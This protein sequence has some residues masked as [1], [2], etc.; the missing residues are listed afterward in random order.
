MTFP[1]P[2]TA[3]PGGTYTPAPNNMYYE[4]H[5]PLGVYNAIRKLLAQ[6]QDSPNS[7]N[8][9]VDASK[10]REWF[11][12]PRP[13]TQ[14]AIPKPTFFYASTT[15]FMLDIFGIGIAPL[16]ASSPAPI[17]GLDG[18]VFY[19]DRRAINDPFPAMI[20]P[21]LW[22][23]KKVTYSSAA[24]PMGLSIAEGAQRI[25][26]AIKD[27]PG[28][29][30]LG[31]HGQG[32]AVMSRVLKD[33][34]SGS[35][36]NR[37]GDLIAAT[38]FGNPSR[39]T[40]KLW[41][42]SPPITSWDDPNSTN[43]HGS[44]P[45]D[46]RLTNTPSLWWEFANADDP[47]ASTGDTT[48]GINWMV[49]IG[50]LTLQF[51]GG[52][53]LV[54]FLVANL[55]ALPWDTIGETLEALG[56]GLDFI[57]NGG[58]SHITYSTAPPTG[59]P[60]NGKTSYQIA[61]EYL[62]ETG[63]QYKASRTLS[64]KTEVLQI[65]FKLPMP[66]NDVAFQAIK[67]PV[68]IDMWYRDRQ[69]NWRA[70]LDENRNPVTLILGS[71]SEESWHSYNAYTS[72]T[73]AKSVQFRMTRLPEAA[74][75]TRPYCVGL[76]N[77]LIRRNIYDRPSGV[78]AT[79]ITEDALGNV[80][81]TYIKD[82]DAPKAID[83]N[84]DTFWRSS[85]QPSPDAVVALYLDMRTED[86]SP[87]LVD[88]LYI[89]PVY[90]GNALNIYYTNDEPEG[91]TLEPSPISV[92][93]TAESH[94]R[95]QAGRGLWDVATGAEVSEF[96]APLKVGPLVKK[97]CWIGVEW[98]PDFVATSPPGTNPV[99]LE[100]IPDNPEPGQFWPR[101]YYDVG[102]LGYGKI[103]LEFTNGTTS[104]LF[105][106]PL[107]PPLVQYEPLRIVA[108]WAYDAPGSAVFITV[109]TKNQEIGNTY[110]P[111]TVNLPNFITLDGSVSF[112]KFRGTFT[113]HIIKL[114]AWQDDYEAFLSSP[115]AYTD[116]DPIVPDSDGQVTSSSLDNSIFSC[117]WTAQRYPVGGT[118]PSMHVDRR[119]TPI[120]RDY[121]VQ[122]G[123]LFFPRQIS[124]K[125]LKLEFSMLTPEPYPVYD[126]GIQTTYETFPISVYADIT[127][128]T[129]TT[130]V[131]PG[132]TTTI[133]PG[134]TQQV[135][136]PGALENVTGAIKQ[137]IN[138][139]GNAV[140]GLLGSI[141][142]L[143][144]GIASVNWL[145]P[146]S[147]SAAI[148]ASS[149]STVQPVTA[150]I[151]ASSE[152]PSI[153]NTISTALGQSSGA[154]SDPSTEIA[155]RTETAS[156]LVYRR[157]PT[158][159]QVLAGQTVNQITG[160]TS[161]QG[162]GQTVSTPIA[163]AISTSFA[164]TVSSPGAAPVT[165]AM[166]KDYWL[167]PGALLKMPAAIMEGIFLGARWGLFGTN[168]TVVTPD[169]I[170]TVPTT[171]TVTNTT[172]TTQRVRFNST[173]THIYRR[174][175]VT[176]TSAIGYFAGI[177]E[178]AAYN[179]TYIDYEDPLSF[180]FKVYDPDQW[181]FTNVKQLTTGA[182]TTN[183]SPY[184]DADLDFYNLDSWDMVGA[185][186]WDGTQDNYSGNRVGSATITATGEEVSL[187]ANSPFAVSPDDQVVIAGSV[188]YVDAESDTGADA[189]VVM[190]IITYN[191][192]EVVDEVSLTPAPANPAAEGYTAPESLSGSATRVE[193]VNPTGK[194]DGV[195]FT[196]LLGTYNVP[197]DGV[198]AIAVRFRITE[199]VT[200]GQFWI[201]EAKA[202]PRNGGRAYLYDRFITFSKFSKVVCN[203]RD[204]GLRRSDR[205]WARTDPL[206]TN[207]DKNNLAW[208]TTPSTMPPGMWG[209]QF[210]DWADEE[211][212]WG[213]ARATVAIWIDPDR[214]YK[215]NRA[216][217]FRR[218]AGTGSA[219]IRIIQQT[220]FFPGAQARI[221]VT[222]YKPI[223]NA[224]TI[225]LRL[226]RVSDGV[227]IYEETISEVPVDQWYTYQSPFFEV[228]D[229]LD[230]VYIVEASVSGTF[231]DEL[232]LSD[233]YTEV[234]H[235]RY[236]M[237]LGGV[238]NPS[239]VSIDVTE[240]AHSPGDAIV[241]CTEPTNEVSLEVVLLT[242]LAVAYGV[243]MTPVY[244]Q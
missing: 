31:G 230:Q 89:D 106:A 99:L 11:S 148:Q 220:N 217:H 139:I 119:W 54:A 112:S 159:P 24:F 208:Y 43:N 19:W 169:Q 162:L 58:G 133:I 150:A 84:P 52:Q 103:V 109:K 97:N 46:Q 26:S 184:T 117:D 218:A 85:P 122:R 68:Q 194:T 7:P 27:T 108:G 202:E 191:N 71:S 231:E 47:I 50:V 82:W 126:A 121:V 10:G 147:V 123:K 228:P 111:N 137:G 39:Q 203:F 136:T 189:R 242:P 2:S 156:S 77:V 234:A 15:S 172:S 207:I 115:I 41:P 244:L 185:W 51:A 64:Q 65:N 37:Q 188:K 63:Q 170:I 215:G 127:T 13:A 229:T 175:V 132:T 154:S 1:A 69:D 196:H 140:N 61:L 135:H 81:E 118:T 95:W 171:E 232:Y 38:M 151:G 8:P 86:G 240:L 213:N 59:N 49:T 179:T 195:T 21:Q 198:D 62:R 214:M 33:I 9:I 73:I 236:L 164:P 12:Q 98:T 141:G 110:V 93:P 238:S 60:K 160:T 124:A 134:S 173:E 223:Q 168:S 88:T 56:E 219:G 30:A 224:N 167:F 36:K 16:G 78:R 199:G 94:T 190:D 74:M 131:V 114:S 177:R 178:I 161:S 53:D 239:A 125:Y 209:D 23:V 176:R 28:P 32:A 120:W 92:V 186:E 157:K 96:T 5:I 14:G 75:G 152:S 116:P 211:V 146:R 158:F 216:L 55:F 87:Q 221:C 29:F 204:S 144:G 130:S 193:I 149:V 166:A 165:P 6:Q 104:K 90:T 45:T 72:P 163:T 155:L 138:T 113:S 243:T 66:I 3:L 227:Y 206:N 18:E 233:L 145:D 105:E 57:L 40:G 187:V 4:F 17:P 226:R 20:D 102:N 181:T 80:V 79:T 67:V 205:M 22:N 107:S 48:A 197:P 153:P 91:V 183:G 174:L 200:A 35:L 44:F 129:T 142:D 222:F 143:I 76:R 83:N 237:R 101:L 70:M 180:D 42:G 235:V 182:V 241:T 34:Q 25:I 100:F 201:A 128:T 210:A 192:G 212:K 225:T